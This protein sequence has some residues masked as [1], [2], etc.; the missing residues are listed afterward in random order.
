MRY[1]EP[2]GS[3]G[4]EAPRKHKTRLLDNFT[5]DIL[6]LYF[7]FSIVNNV[8]KNVDVPA[9]KTNL[10]TSMLDRDT[11]DSVTLDNKQIKINDLELENVYIIS[12]QQVIENLAFAV[13][14][15]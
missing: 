8:N 9:L 3:Q 14:D 1:S 2:L 4:F 5:I 13:F 15:E 10:L 12:P 7:Q 11:F 6:G